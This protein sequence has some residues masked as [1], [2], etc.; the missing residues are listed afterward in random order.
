MFVKEKKNVPRCAQLFYNLVKVKSERRQTG[1]RRTT[2]TE[3]TS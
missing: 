3:Q 2:K 1:L